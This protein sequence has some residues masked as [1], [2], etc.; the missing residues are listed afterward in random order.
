MLKGSRTDLPRKVGQWTNQK[1]MSL[2][3]RI[4][5]SSKKLSP[6]SWSASSDPGKST[7]DVSSTSAS[8][9]KPL[10]GEET[11]CSVSIGKPV[12]GD[13]AQI[14]RP[15]LEFHSMQAS[16]QQ[17]FEKM[18]ENVDRSCILP[19]IWLELSNL[20]FWG[21][22][23]RRWQLLSTLDRIT[24]RTWV[25]KNVI[26]KEFQNLFNVNRRLMMDEEILN[27]ST[28]RWTFSHG[29]DRHSCMTR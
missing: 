5:L 19:K 7:M 11:S 12:R 26:S 22:W 8:I 27:V 18:S 3:A 25:C 28:V 24:L 16:N 6:H 14:Q 20:L 4:F 1:Q 9:G 13:S 15:K 29:R 23:Q 2:V 10:R 21:L 17:Y